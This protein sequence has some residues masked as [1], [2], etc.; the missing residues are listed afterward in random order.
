MPSYPSL[1]FLSP[2][3]PLAAEGN[4]VTTKAEADASEQALDSLK[5]DAYR[6]EAPPDP[7]AGSDDEGDDE[8]EEPGGEP[9]EG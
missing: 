8:P 4:A 6:A 3:P 2:P 1:F 7:Q 5:P 9:D